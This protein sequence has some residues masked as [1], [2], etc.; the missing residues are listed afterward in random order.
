MNVFAVD[1]HWASRNS[2]SLLNSTSYCDVCMNGFHLSDV[3]K[4]GKVVHN[5]LTFIL[6]CQIASDNKG[7][8]RAHMCSLHERTTHIYSYTHPHMIDN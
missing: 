2:A 4:R 1:R 8:P 5:T 3:I 7:A 6:N